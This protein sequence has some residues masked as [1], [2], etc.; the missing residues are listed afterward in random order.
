MK[1]FYI[2]LI[3]S[4]L[5]ANGISQNLIPNGDFELGPDSSSSGW[6]DGAFDTIGGGCSPTIY[7][8]GPY[9]WSVTF[10]SPDRIVDM[11]FPICNWDFTNARSGHAYVVFAGCCEAGKATLSSSLQKDSIYHLCYLLSL[12]TFRGGTPFSNYVEFRFNSGGNIITSPTINTTEWKYFDTIFVALTNSTEI[13]ISCIIN[14]GSAIN[15][16][17]VSLI[18]ITGTSISDYSNINRKINIYPNPSIGIFYIDCNESA[19]IKV[20]NSLG[21][22]VRNF[23]LP[24]ENKSHIIDCSNLPKGIYFLQLETKQEITTKKLL[25][26]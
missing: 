8:G 20:Y 26:N 7:I 25:I 11:D 6:W 5:T 1:K 10:Q 21:K 23:L 13:E 22:K 18:K 19:D 3:L 4:F 2:I 24:K 15:V 17:S 12:Q 16:D 14:S 9:F